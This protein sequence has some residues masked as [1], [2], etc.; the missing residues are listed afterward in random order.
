[1][2]EDADDLFGNSDATDAKLFGVL[3]EA[4]RENPLCDPN[5]W[6]GQNFSNDAKRKQIAN[7]AMCATTSAEALGTNECIDDSSVL[8]QACNSL[9]VSG[10]LPHPR[11]GSPSAKRNCY[12]R[13][14]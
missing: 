12:G 7:E 9:G 3:R 11:R 5:S 14:C 13:R 10:V 2:D 6:M 1:M 4:V 8:K